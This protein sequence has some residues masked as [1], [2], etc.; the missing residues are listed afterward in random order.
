[1]VTTSP[2]P[3]EAWRCGRHLC[4]ADHRHVGRR[5]PGGVTSEVAGGL[6]RHREPGAQAVDAGRACERESANRR[7]HHAIAGRRLDRRQR[8]ELVEEP[9]SADCSHSGRAGVAWPACTGCKA[10]PRCIARRRCRRGRVVFPDA[11]LALAVAA[12]A[13]FGS[14]PAAR[15]ACLE[16]DPE[17]RMGRTCEQPDAESFRLAA[18]SSAAWPA[19]RARDR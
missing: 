17:K 14:H 1:M 19:R 10:E 7:S 18:A 5:P 3:S 15:H 6:A 8:R 13:V 2:G 12:G 11:A 16:A 4:G 9:S